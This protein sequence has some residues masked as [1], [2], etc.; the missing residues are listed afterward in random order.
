MKI[1]LLSGFL[2][3][4]KTTAIQS[5]SRILADQ[6]IKTAVITNDQ[7]IRL[8]DAD[9]FKQMG[10]PGG[11]VVN[12]CFCCN[13]NE[14]DRNIQS[15]VE[16]AQPEVIFAESVGS[17]TDI[18]ATVLKP[19]RLYRP[20]TRVTLSVFAD[21]L[22][23][24]MLLTDRPALFDDA[25]KYIY[26]KQLEE[27]GL[28][29]VNKVDLLGSTQLHDLKKIMEEQYGN[30]LL[31]YQ[32]S[33]DEN[34]TR[35]W[36]QLLDQAPSAWIPPSMEIDYAVYGAG[37][38]RLAWLDQE[39]K[40]ESSAMEANQGA[41]SLMQ[42]IYHQIAIRQYPIGHL[43]FLLNGKEKIS[44]T[45]ASSSQEPDFGAA[46]ASSALLL[47]NARVQT[48]P[49]ILSQLVKKSVRTLEERSDMRV[50]IKSISAFQP[51]FPTPTHRMG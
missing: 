36:L 42:D 8:V 48:E 43:K 34:S 40:I 30:K 26:F 6:G 7:G 20:E 21:A 44:F 39:I 50:L 5:G 46:P 11:Q 51:G 49:G 31:Y 14:L 47:L 45:T 29:I 38:A 9:F 17:C 32:N 12:G 13:Y 2:G 41:I 35:G 16:T 15:L 1:H 25:V 18:I 10:L 4:G 28:L 23:L 22:L 3:S 33:R 24:H 27:A 37:E 19:L